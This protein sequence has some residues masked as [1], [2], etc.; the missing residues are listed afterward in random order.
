MKLQNVILDL[1]SDVETCQCIQYMYFKNIVR[2]YLGKI[3]R[4]ITKNKYLGEPCIIITC[5]LD[6]V[7]LYS[8]SS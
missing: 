6:Y 4:Y 3:Q 7:N 1:S 2:L 5:D 8:S